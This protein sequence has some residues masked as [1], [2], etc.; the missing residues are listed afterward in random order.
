MRGSETQNVL[1]CTINDGG[2][3][4]QILA[5]Y[6]FYVT[7]RGMGCNPVIYEEGGRL[8]TKISEYIRARCCISSDMHVHSSAE[9]YLD[10]FDIM[11]TGGERKWECRGDETLDT[12][13]LHFGREDAGRIAYAPSFGDGCGLPLGPKN[14]AA[15]LLKRFDKIGAADI[16]TLSLLDTEFGISADEVCSPILLIDRYPHFDIG[17]IEGLFIFAFFEKYDGRKHAAVEMAEKTIKYRVEDY[18][19]DSANAFHKSVDEY[20]NAVEKSSLIITDSPAVTQL[21]IVYEK[22][23]ILMISRKENV[24]H[25]PLLANLGLEERIIYVEDDIHEKKYLCRK[26]IKYGAVSAR[27]KE[28]RLSS[29]RWLE[30][31]LAAKGHY[32]S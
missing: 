19:M 14:T 28:L 29:A 10:T 26:P 32:G 16:G 31:C 13:F 18:S 23:F 3:I 17:E 8:D 12:C 1:L 2:N 20:L 27:L 4:S 11:L 7:I 24:F 22:P 21:A 25:L 6:A 30:D 9:E 15:F 5:T